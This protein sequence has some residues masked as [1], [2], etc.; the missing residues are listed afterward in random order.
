[1]TD[2]VTEAAP[3]VGEAA[4]AL[5]EAAPAPHAVRAPRRNHPTL[6]QLAAL[7]PR[8]FGAS[9]APLKRGIFQDLLAAH[10]EA[11]EKEALKAALGIHTRSTRYLQVVAT[12]AQR[13]DLQGQPVEALAPEHVHHAMVELW[14]RRA[15][16][17]PEAEQ[18][19]LRAHWC[20][21][22]ARA[23]DAS[24]LSREAY[25]ELTR[26]RDEAANLL[27]DE[28][29]TEAATM[30]AKDEALLRAFENGASSTTVDAFADMYGLNPRVAAQTLE[31]AR[32]RRAPTAA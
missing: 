23:F 32:R 25:A 20:A 31:R 17:T 10:P 26:T 30:A 7:Y 11:F 4:P 3:A 16:R 18:L 24:G 13:R 27:L 12:G 2:S 19:A 9:P 5:P 21:R 1:M 28:A 22:I 15:G 8:L 14:R 29:L 6:E